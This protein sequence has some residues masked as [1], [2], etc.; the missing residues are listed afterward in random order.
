MVHVACGAGLGDNSPS[1]SICLLR[2]ILTPK[3]FVSG[4]DTSVFPFL[5]SPL[6]II[7][8]VITSKV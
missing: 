7:I 8:V 1:I 4:A 2:S 6:C 5:L 3:L